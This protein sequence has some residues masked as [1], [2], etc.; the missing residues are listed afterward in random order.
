INNAV[1]GF[2]ANA[3]FDAQFITRF[4]D[5]LPILQTREPSEITFSGEFAQLRPGVAETRAVSE[6]IRNNEL[7]SD[8]E[9]G[10]AFIDDFEGANINIS[11]LNATRWNLASA[12]AA[13]PGY[14]ADIPIFE[15]D[16]FPGMPVTNTQ[17]RLDRSDLRSQF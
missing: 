4:L 9:N 11:L 13:V 12:P 7:F 16:D 14:D 10:L 5:N 17:A 8:E 1:I 6:A 15:E 2:D 3:E